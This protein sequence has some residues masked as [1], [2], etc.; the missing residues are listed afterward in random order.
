MNPPRRSLALA[1]RLMFS[2]P[3]YIGV[4]VEGAELHWTG[5]ALPLCC[6]STCASQPAAQHCTLSGTVWRLLCDP[7]VICPEENNPE[8]GARLTMYQKRSP[9]HSTQRTSRRYKLQNLGISVEQ[10]GE[11]TIW[12]SLCR[13]RWT[14]GYDWASSLIYMSSYLSSLKVFVLSK[15]EKILVKKMQHEKICDF[16][17]LFF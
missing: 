13:C 16:L 11:S 12:Q 8:H 2:K 3:N 7:I 15:K 10:K 9:T 17:K 1:H 5:C 14:S 4:C 6:F